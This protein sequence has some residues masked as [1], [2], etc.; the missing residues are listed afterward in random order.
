MHA[1]ATCLV[2]SFSNKGVS[3]AGRT[4]R[5][6][7][8]P[9]PA[10]EACRGKESREEITFHMPPR[11]RGRGSRLGQPTRW[12]PGQGVRPEAPR[13]A[14]GPRPRPAHSRRPSAGTRA[15][16]REGRMRGHGRVGDLWSWV[17]L[18]RAAAS[19]SGLAGC[20]VFHCAGCWVSIVRRCRDG[21]C[22]ASLG[23]C[24][25]EAPRSNQELLFGGL[26]RLLLTAVRA[27][28]D[29]LLRR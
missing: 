8:H 21:C 3:A 17:V 15:G 23:G 4:C 2:F 25:A 14:G 6:S 9:H 28:G 20:W 13:G 29:A 12:G 24:G 16:T 18:R 10:A 1:S 7:S 22:G 11:S 5:V 19:G 26:A 27:G